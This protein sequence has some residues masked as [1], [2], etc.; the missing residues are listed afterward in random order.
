MRHTNRNRL[1][2]RDVQGKAIENGVRPAELQRV[3]RIRTDV[4][5][6]K[7]RHTNRNRLKGRDVQGKAIENGVRP[8]E[9]QVRRRT[10]L[11]QFE[12]L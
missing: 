2:G 8:A 10:P 3:L 5:F 7:M 4:T 12:C 1:K 9:L 11:E 6:R